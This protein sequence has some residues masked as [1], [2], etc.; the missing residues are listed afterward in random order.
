VVTSDA[1]RHRQ[2]GIA[3]WLTA[4]TL[5]GL[6]G[7]GGGSSVEVGIPPDLNGPVISG[8]VSL[9]NGDVAAA[10][11]ALHRLAQAVV[12]RVEALVAVD[13]DV[14]PVG[15]GVEV[16]LIQI[17]DRNIVN[18]EIRNGRILFR[19]I[20]DRN[21]NYAVRLPTGSGPGDCRFY[22]EVGESARTRAFVYAAEPTLTN[23]NFESEATVRLLLEEIRAGRTTLCA[24]SSSDIQLVNNAVDASPNEVFG[25]SITAVNLSAEVAAAAD[26]AVQAAI[27]QAIGA[28]T[29][30]PTTTATS[31]APATATS[32][33]TGGQGPTAT[34]G[35]PTS[36]SGPQTPTA[37]RGVRTATATVGGPATR[38][39][40]AGASP[41]STVEEPTPTS[42]VEGPTPTS[43]AEGATPTDTAASATPTI[44]AVVSSTPTAVVTSTITQIPAATAT[45]TAPAPA[46]ATRTNTAIATATSTA[47]AQ[48][49]PLPGVPEINLG[50]VA[51]SA[52][53]VVVLPV[54]LTTNGAVVAAT[55]NDI[56]FDATEVDVVTLAG[57]PDCTIDP[58]LVGVKQLVADVASTGGTRKR[59]RIGIIG[60]ANNSAITSGALY[61]CRF[62]LPL[63]APF[64]VTLTNAPEAS[65]PQGSL[66]NATGSDGG[67]SV[68]PGGASLR[69]M[70]GPVA[71]DG[72][73]TV[74][75]LA[76][77]RGQPLAAIATDI[78]FDPASL[79]VV[80]ADQNDVADCTVRAPIAALGKEIFAMQLADGQQ[81]V[82]RVGLIATNN[83][84]TLPETGG[85]VAMFDCQFD[86]LTPATT[87][88]L[89]HTPE[90]ARP[91]AQSVPLLA[92]PATITAP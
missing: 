22:L 36:T 25:E 72:T 88:V 9:P 56:E 4:V 2:R 40:T 83:N 18:G 50:A 3:A 11:S 76:N 44:S 57:E 41:T 86:V 1:T 58:R 8:G 53:G 74:T 73:V 39:A 30:P 64:A 47:T 14:E 85:A 46:T 10:P 54:T 63:G 75:A 24:L 67:I 78:A 12:A 52:G 28:V 19:A 27:A 66:V 38:T 33:H 81:T 68:T 90:A 35:P 32:T 45:S 61:S 62:A 84:S 48:T 43:T 31:S 91:D 23:V 49:T 89:Q 6:A 79:A 16:R 15:G 71:G 77:G 20:T 69:L 55:S 7:C 65:D 17:D 5:L 42:T 29:P 26:P 37:T 82:L 59:L 34:T 80:D 13:V 92:E 60:T 70:A 51:G 87:I 21:G